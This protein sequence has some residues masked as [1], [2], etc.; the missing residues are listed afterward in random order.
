MPYPGKVTTGDGILK[1]L[2]EISARYQ[3]GAWPEYTCDEP[4]DVYA[5]AEL[6]LLVETACAKL[7]NATSSDGA[8][9]DL[10]RNALLDL[11]TIAVWWA[12]EIRE[13]PVKEG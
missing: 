3:A 1:E 6:W 11:A 8:T 12:R 10:V 2:Y 4:A 5:S 9:P 13:H 7:D